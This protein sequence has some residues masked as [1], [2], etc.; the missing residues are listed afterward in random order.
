MLQHI[1][2]ALYG[3]L[4][5]GDKPD[6]YD[7]ARSLGIEVTQAL[8]VCN[9]E[10]DALYAK[11]RSESNE[12]SHSRIIERIEQIGGKVTNYGLLGP[13]GINSFDLIIDA[14]EEKLKK[15]NGG[16]YES[17]EHNHL[18][19]RSNVYADRK[20]LDAGLVSFV[21]L[22]VQPLL[23]ERVVVSVPGH[24]Y[25]FDLLER[26]YKDLPFDHA[27]QY[28]IAEKARSIVI[29]AEIAHAAK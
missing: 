28:A 24:N 25:D 17:F 8:P 4:S 16:G 7:R 21:S 20:M 19:V 13:N 14:F 26:A 23:F 2:I 1:D 22:N 11:L 29:E 9:Q 3:H 5:H 27:N 6:L 12:S 10:A 18:F 15:L